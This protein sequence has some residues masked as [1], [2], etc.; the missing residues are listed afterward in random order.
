MHHPT[1]YNTEY[2]GDFF[3]GISKVLQ[4]ALNTRTKD[5]K[6]EKKF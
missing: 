4:H 2:K 6:I 1:T 3:N 5:V